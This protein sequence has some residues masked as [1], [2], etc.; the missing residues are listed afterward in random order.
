MKTLGK[1]AI[2]SVMLLHLAK[3]FTPID[4]LPILFISTLLVFICCLPLQGPGFKK[5]TLLFLLA[6]GAIAFYYQ[7]SFTAWLQ[8]FVSMTN[9]IAIIAVM[10]L[11]V[12]PLE[13][14][15]YSNTVA[16]WL[17]KSF[18]KESSL[19]LFAMLVTH[20]FSSFLLFGTVPVMISLFDKAIK[21]Y[22]P[23]YR[24]FLSAAIVRGYAIALLWAP[25]AVIVLLVL[26]VTGVTW[27]DI[28]IPAM[29][30]G[31]IGLAVAYGLEHVTRMNR[32]IATRTV[33]REDEPAAAA[34]AWRQTTHIAL[35]VVGL[36]A[37]VAFFESISLGTGAGP[38]LLAG[39]APAAGC[40]ISAGTPGW[41]RFCKRT[42]R[43][44]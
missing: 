16:Y 9:V 2:L 30:L 6:A 7:L 3:I 18:R 28:F 29:L 35:V 24:R 27:F 40:C 31:A 41:P 43:A 37:L 17:K 13:L 19:F 39:P 12:L 1:F 23:D 10:Q 8:S 4:T 36:I 33:E 32:P 44:A 42:G 14:G 26:Q 20:L 15:G 25:G 38:V 21:N 5:I 11:F 22:I 34:A